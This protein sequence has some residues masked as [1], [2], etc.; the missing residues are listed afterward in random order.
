MKTTARNQVAGWLRSISL[1]LVIMAAGWF[2]TLDEAHAL[3]LDLKFNS[4]TAIPGDIATNLTSGNNAAPGAA[5]F[6]YVTLLSETQPTDGN[7]EMREAYATSGT[8][9]PFANAY[10]RPSFATTAEIQANATGTLNIRTTNAADRFEVSMWHYSAAGVKVA[11]LGSTVTINGATAT[12][13]RAVNFANAAYTLPAGDLLLLQIS[14]RPSAN[15][16]E[17]RVFCN[18]AT[19]SFIT[20]GIQFRIDSSAGVNGTITGP[21]N[22][23]GTAMVDYKSNQTYIATANGGHQIQSF[24]VDNVAVPAAVGLS[25]Y[26]YN[27][28]AVTGVNANHIIDVQYQLGNGNFVVAPGTGGCITVQGFGACPYVAGPNPPWPGGNTYTYPT[29][30]GT[31]IFDVLPDAGYGIEAVSINGVDQGVPIGQTA[32]WSTLPLVLANGSSITLTAT[33]LPYITVTSSAG[34]GGVI[35]PAG[36]TAVLSGQALTFDI[37]PDPD[38]RILAITDN[39]VN[40]GNTTPYTLTNVTVSHNVVVTFTR[41]HTITATAG[42]NGTI[43]PVGDV[44]VDDGG[45]RSFTMTA[46]LGFR[47]ND[48]LIDGSSVGAATSY[49]FTNVTAAHT[50]EVSFV[51]APIPSTYC[52]VPPYI[53]T[54]APPS[55]MLM[56]SVESPMEGAANPTVSCTGTPSALNYTCSSS[57]LGAYDNARNYYGYFENNKCYTYSGTGATGLFSPSGAATNHQC[58]AGTA[59]SGNMLNWS[60]MLAVDAFRKAFTGG[61]RDTDIPK[62]DAT[63]TNGR[64]IIRSATNDG[65]WFPVRPT[66]NNAELYMPVAGTN[67][68]RTI[69]RQGAGVGFAVCNAGQ[70]DCTVTRTVTTGED[71]WPV[72]GAN[73]AAVYS[74]R[75][76]ACD[77]TGG[78]ETRCNSTTNK[79]EGTI[80]KNMDKMRFSLMSFA[81]DNSAGRDGGVLRSNMKWIGP[82]IPNGLK[83][84]TSSPAGAIA[85]CATNAGCA[86]PEKEVNADG[87]FVAVASVAN[88]PEGSIGGYK[89]GVI[90]YINKFAYT[91]GYKGLDPMGELYYQVVRYFKNLTPTQTGNCT[92]LAAANTDGFNFY[93]ANTKTAPTTASGASTGQWR[94]PALYPCSQNYVIAINDANPWL[95]K[96]IPGSAFTANYQNGGTAING[97]NDYCSG[98]CDTDFT[99]SGVQV[100]VETWVNTIGDWEGITGTTM[101]VACEVNASGLCIGGNSGGKNVVIS[102]L[103]RIIGTPPYPAKENSYNVSGLAFYAHMTDLRPDLTGNKHNLTTYMIDTQEPGGSMLVGPKN[104]L[105]LAAK[106]G[107]FLE[108]D[109]SDTSQRVTVGSRSVG[110]PFKNATCAVGNASPNTLCSEW[111]DDNDGT[112]D[113]YFF[114]SDSS[115]VESGLN[116]AFASILNRATSGTAAAVANNRSGERGAN[117]IQAIFYPQWPLNQ[118]IKWLGDVQA[119]WFY[120]DPLVQFSNIYEDSDSNKELNLDQDRTP[121]T[122]SLAVKALWKAGEVLH[123]RS[124]TT[125]AIYTLL[126]PGQVITAAANTFTT[127]NRASLKPLLNM[128][129]STDATTDAIINYVRGTDSGSYRSRTLTYNLITNSW[130]LGDIIN[131]TP[132]IQGS[133]P[134]NT[135]TTDYSDNTY[136]LFTRSNQYKSNNMAYVGSNDGMLHAFRL[137]LV[138]SITSTNKF[139]IAQIVDDTDLGKEEW[140]FIPNNVL[141]FLQNCADANY[142]HQY[143]VDG[144]PLVFDASINL[145]PDPDPADPTNRPGCTGDYWNCKRRTAIDSSNNLLA[146]ASSWRTILLGSM[147]HGGAT[148][149]GNCNETLS[150]D[151]DATNNI[152]CI[153]IPAAGSG[154][155]SYFALDVTSPLTPKFMWEFSDAVLPTAD[156]GLGLTTPG[157]AIVRTNP[158]SLAIPDKTANGRWFAVFASGPTG[159]IDQATRQMKGFSDQNLKLYVVDINPFN[160][161]TT[162]FVKCTTAGQANCNYW[163]FD[164]GI[165][166]AFSHTLYRATIDLDRQSSL[167]NGYYSDDVVYV[168]YNRATLDAS[169]SPGPYPTAWDKGGILRLITNNDPDPANWFVSTLIDG[170]GPVTSNVDILQDRNNKKLWVFFGEG[171]YFYTGDDLNTQRRIFGVMDPCYRNDL[172]SPNTFFNTAITCPSLTLGELSSQTSINAADLVGK[173]GWYI[174]L[175]AASG[176]SGAERIYGKITAEVSGVVTYPTFTPSTD[177]CTSGG[178]TSLWATKYNT[179]GIPPLSSLNAKLVVTTTDSPIPKTIDTTNAFTREGGRKLDAA[180]ETA[181]AAGGGGGGVGG[182]GS[183]ITKPPPVKKMINIQER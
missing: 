135:F 95:D 174:D 120:L 77:S 52:A 156:R 72:A 93:C 134:I 33:F 113:N 63:Y 112:P 41:T 163:V 83:Y 161:T 92:G 87:T 85:T 40:V 70:T 177:I 178:H 109:P 132:Q 86:N 169:P 89:S 42:P 17:G 8:L 153:K 97:A 80:Q 10:Y 9:Y 90:N 176:A 103:G 151:L 73:T 147:G 157:P 108:K 53:N 82:L 48:V 68:T 167:L 130:K 166:Y 15:N 31:Y 173:K 67:L 18:S 164:S 168:S 124:A 38:Y 55:V 144:S 5:N 27:G 16:R 183:K 133:S 121:G 117:V 1:L 84:H 30:T 104:M 11:Q 57:G 155:S 171:R 137:G 34:T 172:I 46:N 91:S 148:R 50:I 180:Y 49:S 7:T 146:S 110:V 126:S 59:W 6:K 61:N 122:D 154:F 116:K 181:G 129:A 115:K 140:A 12:T 149:D 29:A 45:S 75:I 152:D 78:T 36:S 182:G 3:R 160:A 56:L 175:T 74:L 64:T 107:G 158:V 26:T 139:R 69:K 165:K 2:L 13:A 114:A 143:L 105:Y 88:Y 47:I 39:G 119:L 32:L 162:S 79:P 35:S 24:K 4:G 125:R 43:T 14:F 100:P 118:S 101:N 123:A 66:I 127:S 94:D 22:T 142:C 136:S 141:P 145:Y 81:A 60:T 58:A 102:K 96:R 98:N 65:S 28:P 23:P 54:P 20:V 170:I 19:K 138:E 99:D 51:E 37:T 76:L 44:V 106:Y 150:H 159:P 131:S 111:D 128:S 62:G 71:Q 25:S 21:T 179:G